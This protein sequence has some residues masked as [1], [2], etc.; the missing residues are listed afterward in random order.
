MK[1]ET[2]IK[3][4]FWLLLLFVLGWI[5]YATITTAKERKSPN[6]PWQWTANGFYE[7]AHNVWD[8]YLPQARFTFDKWSSAGSTSV[9]KDSMTW[10]YWQSD[11]NINSADRKTWDAANNYCSEL[12]LWWYDDWRLPS[13]K[14]LISIVDLSKSAA[15]MIDTTKFTAVSN[16]YWSSTTSALNT[17]NAWLVYFNNGY[18]SYSS[19]TSNRYVRCVR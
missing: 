13:I 14:E 1:K 7:S 9:I 8:S 2:Y 4:A 6:L 3:V 16:R 17:A 11:G 5:T 15:P 10:L 12:V 18:V 19:K